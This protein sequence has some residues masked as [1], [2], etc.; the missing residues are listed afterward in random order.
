LA[1][2]LWVNDEECKRVAVLAANADEYCRAHTDGYLGYVC[3]YT[4]VDGDVYIDVDDGD[5]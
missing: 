3:E 1:Q 2:W 5:A 4:D